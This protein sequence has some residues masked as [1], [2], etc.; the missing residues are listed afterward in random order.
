MSLSKIPPCGSNINCHADDESRELIIPIDN[1]AEYQELVELAQKQLND[2]N[3]TIEK[4]RFF[5]INMKITF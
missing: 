5:S 2:L 4:L 3:N 1:M